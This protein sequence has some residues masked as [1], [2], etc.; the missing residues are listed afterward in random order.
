MIINFRQLNSYDAGK[1]YHV[2]HD[3]EKMLAE[4]TLYLFQFKLQVNNLFSA[5]FFAL[6]FYT[7]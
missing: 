5:C 4:G 3:Y 2:N 1:I 7:Y 6:T